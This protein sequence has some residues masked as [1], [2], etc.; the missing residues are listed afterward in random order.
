[1]V[2]V[3]RDAVC[4]HCQVATSDGFKK[5]TLLDDS[6]GEWEVQYR[7]CPS[8]K[9][10]VVK[11]SCD[12]TAYPLT[13]GPDEVIVKPEFVDTIYSFFVWPRE[14]VRRF[15]ELDQVPEQYRKDYEEAVAVLPSSARAS[16]AL[17]RRCLQN[18]L[19]NVAKVRRGK[20]ADEIGEF[21]NRTRGLSPVTAEEMQELRELG[22]LALHPDKVEALLPV[23]AQ[24]AEWML[25]TLESLFEFFF[26][27]PKLRDER[28]ARLNKRKAALS[29]STVH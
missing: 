20:L 17:S 24:E 1:M 27:A 12:R 16:A 25:D 2:N 18:L 21:V 9:R 26:V 19:R 7:K 10:I 4:P 29:K 13:A 3:D 22:N 5:S 11:L 8:C 15:S 6:E 14:L 28:K 23:D